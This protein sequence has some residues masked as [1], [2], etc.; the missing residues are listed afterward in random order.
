MAIFTV[1]SNDTLTLN[2]RVFN[3]LASDTVTQIQLPNELVNIKLEHAT[4]EHERAAKES[5]TKKK[6]EDSAVKELAKHMETLAK[7]MEKLTTKD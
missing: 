2:N 4:K 6:E 3:D 1:V 5:E 7:A